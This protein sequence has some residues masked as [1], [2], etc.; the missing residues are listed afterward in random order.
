MENCYVTLHRAIKEN[1]IL[2]WSSCKQPIVIMINDTLKIFSIC[3]RFST[4]CNIDYMILSFYNSGS[5]YSE[6]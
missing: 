6:L 2:S 1:N 3:Q 5:K 4:Q